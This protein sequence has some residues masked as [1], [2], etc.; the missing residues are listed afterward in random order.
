M[1]TSSISLSVQASTGTIWCNEIIDPRYHRLLKLSKSLPS[2]QVGVTLF[3]LE[4]ERAVDH[5]TVVPSRGDEC[6]SRRNKITRNIAVG[7]FD[8][9]SPGQTTRIR[10]YPSPENRSP[11]SLRCAGLRKMTDDSPSNPGREVP[12]HMSTM[13]VAVVGTCDTGAAAILIDYRYLEAGLVKR[14]NHPLYHHV[15]IC[16]F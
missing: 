2:R 10:N 5:R 6:G 16:P 8:Q 7:S 4:F 15:T 3:G 1:P 9:N 14:A 12:F 11:E 13:N